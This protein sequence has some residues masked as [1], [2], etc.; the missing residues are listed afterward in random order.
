MDQPLFSLAACW[1]WTTRR[2]V[3]AAVADLMQRARTW[4]T[5]TLG[6]S[7]SFL[8]GDVELLR[9]DLETALEL[10]REGA[11]RGRTVGPA[12]LGGLNLA[13]EGLVLAQLGRTDPHARPNRAGD[14]FGRFPPRWVLRLGHLELTLGAPRRR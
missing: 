13:L 5:R 1:A 9:G 10:A 7:C 12:T 2:R 4:A 3:R 14:R 6:R 11:G 8:L